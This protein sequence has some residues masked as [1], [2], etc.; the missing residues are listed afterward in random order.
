[1]L[2]LCRSNRIVLRAAGFVEA[3]IEIP[4]AATPIEA[5][6]LLSSLALDPVPMGT[7]V[8]PETPVKLSYYLDGERVDTASGP[9]ELP[10]GTHRL[11]ATNDRYWIDVSRDVEISAGSEVEAAVAVPA[12]T[13]L[14]VFAY[15]PNAKVE[16][17]HPGGRWRYLDDVPLRY[18]I[19]AGRYEVRVTLK[20]T[21]E[22]RTSEIVLEPGD[23]PEVRVS[24]GTA[25]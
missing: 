9:L 6:T 22:T 21:G 16:L 11:R 24:F 14:V 1:D 23:N 8:F 3:S 15:P 12:L 2:D 10:Q 13:E 4:D 5:R 18:R 25:S 7:L 19:A 17:R 20:T